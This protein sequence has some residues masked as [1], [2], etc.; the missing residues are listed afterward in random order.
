MISLEEAHKILI[1]Q[2]TKE[3]EIEI[4][5]LENALGRINAE[6]IICKCDM[7]PF[8]KSAVDGFVCRF[9]DLTN[10]EFD[11][12]E[13]IPAGKF[14]TQALKKG[15]CSKIMTGAPVPQFG[16][17]V[18]MVED[19]IQNGEK[20]RFKEHYLPPNWP[21]KK[22]NI[23]IQ[24]EDIK[25][26]EILLPKGTYIR[27]GE[28]AIIATCGL[29]Q[30]RAYKKTTIGIISTGSELVE[31]GSGSLKEGE[32]FNANSWQLAALMESFGCKPIYYGIAPDREEDTESLLKRAVAENTIVLLSGGV[33]QG[34][35]D[36]VP[37]I[38]KKLGFSI[39]FDR[40]AVQP[41]K[42]TTFATNNGK[43]IFGLPGNPVSAFVQ[44]I[45]LVKPFIESMRHGRHSFKSVLL[46]IGEEYNR[47]SGERLSHIPANLTF[48]G[49][50][51]PSPYNG[52]A[53]ISAI[54][55]CD[56]L[57]KIPI[58]T[59]HLNKGEKVET[60]FFNQV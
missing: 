59:T 60:I 46:P 29:R 12:I 43:Y 32:I 25:Q 2:N 45:L 4:I 26:G 9:E 50:V 48:N 10:R 6:D 35:F 47:K 39:L 22:G 30:F 7:P 44:T 16:E 17:F 38:M 3:E 20:M 21:N 14:P 56:V 41:G 33:S 11:I 13:V 19:C 24:G 49:E 54:S 36:F 53:N 52:S 27:G 8:N 40:I 23:C 55:T 34:D 57:I 1:S 28:I 51:V 31:P 15:C 18:V 58:G 5:S 42:P 37:T